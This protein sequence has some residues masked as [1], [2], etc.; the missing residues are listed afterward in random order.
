MQ[1][2]YEQAMRPGPLM[3]FATRGGSG[4]MMRSEKRNGA[5]G[6]PNR[7]PPR[8]KKAGFFYIFFTLLLSVLLEAVLTRLARRITE[9]HHE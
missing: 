2:T 9:V 1:L 8:R 3:F 7:R 4:Y 5:Y 6:S